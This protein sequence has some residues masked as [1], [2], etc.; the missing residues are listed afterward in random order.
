MHGCRGSPGESAEPVAERDGPDAVLQVALVA[1][2]VEALEPHG[3]ATFDH[4]DT[5]AEP[6]VDAAA[7]AETDVELPPVLFVAAVLG[8]R[9]PESGVADGAVDLLRKGRPNM[10]GGPQLG[11]ADGDI[12]DEEDGYLE[13]IEAEVTASPPWMDFCSSRSGCRRATPWIASWR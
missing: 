2:R 13:I 3:V 9:L 10:Q 1:A 6:D 7:E 12:E 11:R 4:E 5:G 8:V